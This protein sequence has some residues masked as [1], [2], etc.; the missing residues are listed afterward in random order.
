M[1]E[2]LRQLP[3][4][5]KL[6]QLHQRHADAV[7]QAAVHLALD[8]HRVD[9]HAAVVHRQEA[10][11]GDLAGPGV[12]VHHADV[13]A[14]REGE[15]GRVVDDLRVE[16]ALEPFRQLER[17][18]RAECDLLN[19]RALLGVALHEPAPLLPLEVVGR[20]LEHRRRHQLRLVAHRSRDHGRG[21]ARHRG[22]ARPVGA[23]PERRP[24]GVAVHHVDVLRRDAQLLGD[25]LGEGRLV[26]LALGL[27]AHPQLTPCRSGGCAARRRRSFPARGCRGACA[28][29]PR[30]PR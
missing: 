15:V 4:A 5:S 27:A 7:G 29:P 16:A 11:H 2:P 17:S 18:V 8:D 6:D 13:R 26:A 30:R 14:E 23:E 21:G 25:D 28:A 20:A 10:P 3:S 12:D 24:V 22:R 19:R 1:N 9:P